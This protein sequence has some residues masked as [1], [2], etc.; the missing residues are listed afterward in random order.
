MISTVYFNANIVVRGALEPQGN[1]LK[2]GSR[3]RLRLISTWVRR[4]R[5]TK[6]IVQ[7]LVG[8]AELGRSLNEQ[9]RKV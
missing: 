3:G 5:I 1:G 9:D 7:N 2:L 6:V 8:V 4:R